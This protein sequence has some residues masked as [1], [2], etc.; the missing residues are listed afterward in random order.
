MSPE[1][2]SLLG[3]SKKNFELALTLKDE[4]NFDAAANRFYYSV[5]QAVKA[6]ALAIGRMN[7]TTKESVHKTAAAVV[8]DTDKRY[9]RTMREACELRIKADYLCEGVSKSEMDQHFL[10]NLQTMRDEFEAMA[11]SA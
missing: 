9:Y 7:T 1:C 4:D 8:R 11:K 2:E 6:Y 10:N 3:K 5:F